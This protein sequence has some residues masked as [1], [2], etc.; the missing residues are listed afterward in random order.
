MGTRQ[1]QRVINAQ[2]AADGD[3]VKIL[4]I[5][6]AALSA[7]IDPFLLLDEIR[8]E[9]GADYVGGFPPHPHRGFETITYMLE[10]AMRHRDH[11]GNE[12]VIGPGDVQWMT[13]GRGVIHSE[14]PEQSDGLLH[15]FQLW[16]N[17]P[18]AQKMQP[19]AY[20]EFKRKDIP[21]VAPAEGV[22]IAVIAGRLELDE[23]AVTGPVSERSTH[24][25]Y[26]DMELGGGAVIDL[27]VDPGQTALVR[28]FAGDIEGVAH[29]QM[30]LY[31]NGD[32]IRLAA[33]PDGARLLVL[34]A[35]PIREPIV[36]RGPFVMNTPQEIEQAM[37][38]YAQGRLLA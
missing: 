25:T 17:L 19:A 36:Q 4:R 1:L 21:V 9:D 2:P 22:R 32:T 13:A 12:G 7:E 11:M 10:G 34:L 33:G 26:L 3:G 29:G 16:L 27:P 37:R 30:G 8:S 14:M 23:I 24:P 18:A 6:G 28:V 31:A 20:Q 15:G 35:T 38:D 5:A